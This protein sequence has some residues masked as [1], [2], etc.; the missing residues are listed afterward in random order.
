MGLNGEVMPV[1]LRNKEEVVQGAR[2]NFSRENSKKSKGEKETRT[3]EWEGA[4]RG[5]IETAE[6]LLPFLTTV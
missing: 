6:I 1:T 3:G 5:G 4:C 2:K